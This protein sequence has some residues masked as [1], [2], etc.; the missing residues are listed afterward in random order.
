[1]VIDYTGDKSLP[2]EVLEH[3]MRQADG[4]PLF[5]EEM[6]KMFLESD[7]LRETDQ[8]YQLITSL[9]ASMIPMTLQDALMM[10]LDRLGESKQVAQLGACIGR[11]F[12]YALLQ[13]LSPM[14]EV[15]LQCALQQLIDAEILYQRGSSSDTV[16]TFKHALIRDTAYDAL[17]RRRRQL[18]HG[19]IA[20]ALETQFSDLVEAQPEFVA[21]HYTEAGSNEQAIVWWQRAGKQAIEHSAHV[22]A[23]AHLNTGLELLKTLPDIPKRAQ[24]ELDLLTLLGPA[25]MAIKDQGTPEAGQAYARAQELCRQAGATPQLFPVLWGLWRYYFNRAEYQTAGALAEQCFRLAQ[26]VHDL[27][28]LLEAHF[29]M[30]GQLL[31]CGELIPAQAHLEQGIRLHL[32]QAHRTLAVHYG[33]DPGAACLGYVGHALWTLGYPDQ[34]LQRCREALALAQELAHPL[35]VASALVYVAITHCCRQEGLAAKVQAEAVRALAHEH[36]LRQWFDLGLFWRG[37]ALMV[38]GQAAEGIAQMRQGLTARRASGIE[39]GRPIIHVG[40]AEAHGKVGQVDEG[41]SLVAEALVL[42]HH[43]GERWWEAELHRLKGELLLQS[44][45]DNQTEAESCFQQAMTIAQTQSAKS[46]ELRAAMSLSR[47]WQQQ[48]KGDAAW[49]L[50][51]PIYSWFTEGFDTVDLQDAKTLL[52]ELRAC[53]IPSRLE[54]R[55]GVTARLRSSD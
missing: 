8:G 34:A 31:Y 25:L 40:L 26:R 28:L 24:H 37:W 54:K 45:P 55:K 14:D 9:P 12:P 15:A 5:I 6:T 23:I 10:R 51:G 7:L 18:S 3:V 46:W 30:G 47:L 36:S 48:G 42:V 27:R 32:P 44:S 16:Y 52:G 4:V 13:I 19:Q 35:T 43:T 1:M 39:Q 21:L 11:C 20:E 41:L 38:Q 49:E 17:P 53:P 22:E 33:F 29:A 50:L 2:V